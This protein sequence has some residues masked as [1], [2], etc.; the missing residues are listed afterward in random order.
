MKTGRDQTRELLEA[1]HQF[2]KETKF[3]RGL[4]QLSH[5]EYMLLMMIYRKS[6]ISET[7]VQAAKLGEYMQVSKPMIS[8]LAN[9][10]EKR[11]YLL[12]CFDPTDH[13]IV[14]FSLTQEGKKILQ[15]EHCT[16]E[17]TMKEIIE[18]MGEEDIDTL[19]RLLHK[20]SRVAKDLEIQ[21]E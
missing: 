9:G 10:L 8:K 19:I 20:L 12:R 7:G 18:R 5:S 15:K 1:V 14:Y 2:R 17:K 4:T 11:G 21:E 6:K 13:R 3:L 16:F